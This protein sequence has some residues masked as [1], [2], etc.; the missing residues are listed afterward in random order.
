MKDLQSLRRKIAML[1]SRNFPEYYLKIQ[2]FG[3]SSAELG[4]KVYGV[5]SNRVEEIEEFIFD[6]NHRYWV[7]SEVAILPF[8]YDRQ[9]TKEYYSA[10]SLCGWVSTEKTGERQIISPTI[11]AV[12]KVNIPGIEPPMSAYTPIG[13]T[14]QILTRPFMQHHEENEDMYALAA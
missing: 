1:M 8:V 7:E 9:E 14:P 6:L 4:I 5:P 2:D 12:K 3:E 13:S 10:E 11:T